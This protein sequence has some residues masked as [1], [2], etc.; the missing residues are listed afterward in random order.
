MDLHYDDNGLIPAIVQHAR[1]GE[2]LMLGY[3]N[4]EALRLTHETGLV[5]FWSR[6][7]Q[8]LWRKGETSGNHLRLVAVRDRLFPH[9][10]LVFGVCNGRL[11][12]WALAE[13]RRPDTGTWL[14]MA[15]YWNTYDDGSVCHGSMPAPKTATVDNLSQWSH[16]FFA[17]RFTG[18]NLGI[19]Q[20][21]HP[22]GFLGLWRS[23]AGKKKF[24]VEY[25]LRKRRLRETLC[26][27]R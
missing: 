24:P 12:V 22:E 15:P 13:D 6:S 25:L 16:A 21:S 11:M 17:S 1:S 19:Q 26:R 5:T 18:S 3:M 4:E 7:R 2:V 23:L 10:P 8:A 9:P 20:C 14:Y 27:N